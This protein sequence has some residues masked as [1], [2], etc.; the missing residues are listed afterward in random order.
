MDSRVPD[1]RG[2]RWLLNKLLPSDADLRA[3]VL[4]TFGAAEYQ[5]LEGIQQ[6]TQLLNELLLRQSDD[7][8]R[9]VE[10]LQAAYP[11]EFARSRS[12][13]ALDGSATVIENSAEAKTVQLAESPLKEKKT[14]LLAESPFKKDGIPR[15]EAKMPSRGAPAQVRAAGAVGPSTGAHSL[16]EMRWFV[17][18]STVFLLGTGLVALTA[19]S[20]KIELP[21]PQIVVVQSPVAERGR[22]ADRKP[23]LPLDTPEE[24]TRK[25]QQA[26]LDQVRYQVTPEWDSETRVLLRLVL[27]LLRKS[28]QQIAAMKYRPHQLKEW[29]Q[30]THARTQLLAQLVERIEATIEHDPIVPPDDRVTP[31]D[32]GVPG[33]DLLGAVA[34]PEQ[35]TPAPPSD[36]TLKN[37]FERPPLAPPL[38][39]SKSWNTKSVDKTEQLIEKLRTDYD[40]GDYANVVSSVGLVQSNNLR[41][42]R[43]IG[44]AACHTKDTAVINNAYRRLD[45]AGRHYLILICWE[46]GIINT[47]NQ[48]HLRAAR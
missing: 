3:F 9:I 15:S 10:A 33:P 24:F 20:T 31:R 34:A 45:P 28:N 37:P 35:S 18:F 8:R 44:A 21:A 2:V 27:A 13:V 42:W 38:R 23:P 19:R 41:A 25:V 6:R 39:A 36:G 4:D 16:R 5:Q 26:G 43:L 7:L 12:V 40:K 22:E 48:F 1:S 14:V 30:D 17:I 47:G 32:L 11:G 29:R 46:N